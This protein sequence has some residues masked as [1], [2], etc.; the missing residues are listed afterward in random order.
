MCI[1]GE[2]GFHGL[3]ASIKC[4]R[5]LPKGHHSQSGTKAWRPESHCC[6]QWSNIPIVRPP[7]VTCPPQ[8]CH[9]SPYYLWAVSHTV[10]LFFKSSLQ[11]LL[12]TFLAFVSHQHLGLGGVYH[13]IEEALQSKLTPRRSHT[14]RTAM[15]ALDRPHSSVSHGQCILMR[16]RVLLATI[17]AAMNL[18]K[19]VIKQLLYTEIHFRK[20]EK[21][22]QSKNQFDMCQYR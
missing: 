5:L 3:Q 19:A 14:G 11:H 9:E 16:V 7:S 10:E 20:S 4:T 2:K 8:W 22:L 1:L 18:L 13:P 21:E 6:G 17:P 15:G 12:K